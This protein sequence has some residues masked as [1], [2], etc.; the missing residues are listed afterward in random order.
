M[1]HVEFDQEAMKSGSPFGRLATVPLVEV[2][3]QDPV[4]ATD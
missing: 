4:G 3:E 1:I 2:D